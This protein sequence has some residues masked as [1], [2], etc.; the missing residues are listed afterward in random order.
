MAPL[1]CSC[2]T[3]T[4]HVFA[5]H[6]RDLDN[7]LNVRDPHLKKTGALREKTMTVEDM[8]MQ[9]ERVVKELSDALI[10]LRKMSASYWA[11]IS[12]RWNK[13]SRDKQKALLAAAC[14]GTPAP[15]SP[16]FHFLRGAKGATKI[17]AS[18]KMI[19][20]RFPEMNL[21]D[22]TKPKFLLYFIQS[23]IAESPELFVKQDYDAM[24]IGLLTEVLKSETVNGYTMYLND[25]GKDYG[26]LACWTC[27][28]GALPD[29]MNGTGMP[30][31]KGL[32]ILERQVGIMGFLCKCCELIV[33]DIEMYLTA[34]GQC[35]ALLDK[36]LASRSGSLVGM[37]LEASYRVPH[38]FDFDR[39]QTLIEAKRFQAMDSVIMLKEDPGYFSMT[40]EEE[41]SNSREH[42]YNEFGGR[43]S[44]KLSEKC[45]GD[46]ISSLLLSHY[47]DL[48]YWHAI[49]CQLEELVK[50][51]H[52]LS[53]S[54]SSKENSSETQKARARV[55]ALLGATLDA[56]LTRISAG[57][58]GAPGFR[59]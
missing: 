37:I 5:T 59:Q 6:G 45:W 55:M 58:A 15:H 25:F 32:L 34:D 31:G 17:D 36:D 57:F 51:S 30:P 33:H 11:T 41:A 28:K 38:R 42:L 4:T 39:V 50:T 53:S 56:H 49:S 1:Q 52:E 18:S 3:P 22:L 13:K 40:M 26:R 2:K 19:A 43:S 14:P 8:Q 35:E 21:E 29:C 48:F 46:S 23:W 24:R 10:K 54:K 20:L 12:K 16:D 27:A 47:H 9:S 44:R 7:L